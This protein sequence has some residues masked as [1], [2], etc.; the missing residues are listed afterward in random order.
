MNLSPQERAMFESRIN[1]YINLLPEHMHGAM[2][3][4]VFDRIEAGGFLNSVLCNNLKEAV[5]RADHINRA[6][7]ADIV[8]FCMEALPAVSWGS[9][10]KVNKWLNNEESTY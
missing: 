2:N 7:M 3:R 10:E 6:A 4:Y 8:S 9:P 5:L 1:R